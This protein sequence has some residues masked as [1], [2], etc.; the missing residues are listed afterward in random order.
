MERG[1]TEFTSSPPDFWGAM[2]KD[3]VSMRRSGVS[4]GDLAFWGEIGRGVSSQIRATGVWARWSLSLNQTI[5]D[6]AGQCTHTNMENTAAVM[7]NIFRDHFFWGQ[8]FCMHSPSRLCDRAGFSWQIVKKKIPLFHV[9]GKAEI[10]WDQDLEEIWDA[11]IESKLGAFFFLLFFPPETSWTSDGVC[12]KSCFWCSQRQCVCPVRAPAVASQRS[13]TNWF[14]RLNTLLMPGSAGEDEPDRTGH[15][16][17]LWARL[18]RRDRL[19]HVTHRPL[20]LASDV[21][22]WE[23]LPLFWGVKTIA[24]SYCRFPSW[25]STHPVYWREFNGRQLGPAGLDPILNH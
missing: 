12:R 10:G 11:D 3:R 5:S 20:L 15:G 2:A 21:H 7:W 9:C 17:V 22:L 19:A 6:G 4:W 23:S 16:L 13:Y 25:A 24:H 14:H 1:K 8:F 18:Q